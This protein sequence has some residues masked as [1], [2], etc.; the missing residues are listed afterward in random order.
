MGYTRYWNQTGKPITQEFLDKVT[1]VLNDCKNKGISIRNGL[2]E[3]EPV[4]DMEKVVFNGDSDKNT[5]HESFVI[6]NNTTGFNFCKTARKPYDYAVRTILQ[7]AEEMGIVDEVSSDGE[8][9]VIISDAKYLGEPEPKRIAVIV[10]YSFDNS[11]P[12]YLFD[13]EEDAAA[14]IRK[15]FNEEVRIDTEENGYVIGDNMD[16]EINDDGSY[17]KIVN[18]TP[19]DGD[20]IT[21][22][23]MEDVRN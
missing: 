10:K 5:D 9:D 17:A 1:E 21:E 6:R 16:I 12:V 22:W 19:Y 11:T 8:N 23:C 4:V 20:A 18:H 7:I 13:T 3:N 2:G 14:E 15:Q